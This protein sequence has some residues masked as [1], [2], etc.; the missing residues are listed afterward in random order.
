MGVEAYRVSWGF[1]I[2]CNYGEMEI[3][4]DGIEDLKEKVRK[5]NL[6][7]LPWDEPY[8]DFGGNPWMKIPREEIHEYTEEN[9]IVTYPQSMEK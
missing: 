5:L 9:D 4:A 7:S 8:E 6:K 1:L 2:E 3:E